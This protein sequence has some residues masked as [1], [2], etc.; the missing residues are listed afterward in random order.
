MRCGSQNEFILR[1]NENDRLHDKL[2]HKALTE[3]REF[4]DTRGVSL[5]AKE[6]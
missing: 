3:S 4:R 5:A 6:T 1:T 2:L